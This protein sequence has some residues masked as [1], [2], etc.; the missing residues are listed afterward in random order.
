MV[1]WDAVSVWFV[2]GW[3]IRREMVVCAA[4]SVM[5]CYSVEETEGNGYV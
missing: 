3:G 2:I 5:V 4:I 1:M